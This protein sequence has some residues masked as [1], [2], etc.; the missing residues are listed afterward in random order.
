MTQG[1]RNWNVYQA[2]QL[3]KRMMVMGFSVINPIATCCAP[4]AWEPAM[5]HSL[6]L[7]NDLP[8][9]AAC[10]LVFRMPGESYGAYLETRHAALLGIPILHDER[11]LK[12]WL[13]K[14]REERDIH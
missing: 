1:D 8:I 12:P 7:E 13:E 9:V 10:E 14:W 4:F 2:Y 11:H 3:Q 5:T 6:W